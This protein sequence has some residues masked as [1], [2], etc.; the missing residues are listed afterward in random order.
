MGTRH[1]TLSFR[2]EHHHGDARECHGH[3]HSLVFFKVYFLTMSNSSACN[4]IH[5][6]MIVECII[7]V[8]CR[9]TYNELKV[10]VKVRSYFSLVDREP[11]R[12][13]GRKILHPLPV[14][15]H[16]FSLL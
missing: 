1:R 5:S 7:V 4:V 15:M 2:A 6:D 8:T 11:K 16:S 13:C 9:E 3:H 14:D 10:V 12:F